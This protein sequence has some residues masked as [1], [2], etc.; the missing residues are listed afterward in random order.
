[1][2]KKK[3]I[4]IIPARG[5]SKRIP[6]KNYKKFNGGP[7]IVNTI[8]KL[9]ESKIFDRII[10]STD[11][12]KIANISKKMGA[13]IPFIRSKFLSN[14]Y[15]STLSVVSNCV[16]FLCNQGHEFDYVCCVYAPNPFLQIND[17]KKGLN[18]IKK[19]KYNYVLSAITFQFPFFRSFTYSRSQGIK[20]LISKN[21]NKRSQDLKEIICDAGQFYWG[22]CSAFQAGTPFF[23][24]NAKPI[25]FPIS[26]VQD[27]D[28]LEDWNYAQKLG[29][30]INLGK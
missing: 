28:T 7:I 9:K 14:D 3:V 13:E 4:A 27:I 2:I 1:M 12:K 16:R 30:I 10:V 23:S 26:R 22:T 15:A 18:K 24:S 17:L 29:K 8:R 11:S 5:R 19:N 6:G 21:L 20:M 25:I